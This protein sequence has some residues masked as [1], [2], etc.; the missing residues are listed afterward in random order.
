MLLPDSNT[1]AVSSE[2]KRHPHV[3][4]HAL[5]HTSHLR[6]LDRCHNRYQYSLCSCHA[7]PP[8]L[9]WDRKRRG[10]HAQP[11][12][13]SLIHNIF[14]IMRVLHNLWRKKD[15]SPFNVSLDSHNVKLC[16]HLRYS[17]CFY[18]NLLHLQCSLGLD[19]MEK[20]KYNYIF[21]QISWY[22]WLLVRIYTMTFLINNH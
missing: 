3:A 17:L 13:V 19:H 11:S 16:Y 15:L 10:I 2:S 18:R 14:M 5:A 1:H 4:H 21:S 9:F 22:Q 12:D 20:I 6:A 7:K 8:P